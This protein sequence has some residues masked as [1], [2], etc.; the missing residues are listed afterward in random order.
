MRIKDSEKIQTLKENLFLDTETELILKLIGDPEKSSEFSGN[1]YIA[2]C[3]NLIYVINHENHSLHLVKSRFIDDREF[4]KTFATVEELTE[5][6]NDLVKNHKEKS[7][8]LHHRI[9]TINI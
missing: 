3:A 9:E 4:P 6:E 8:Y 1:N 5:S 2:H 7:E